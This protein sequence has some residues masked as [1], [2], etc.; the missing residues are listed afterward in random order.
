MLSS[1]AAVVLQCREFDALRDLSDPE[2]DAVSRRRLTET[3]LHGLLVISKST[4]E[5]T[6]E[7]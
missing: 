3:G 5:D 2:K 6:G 1:M 4:E 7:P